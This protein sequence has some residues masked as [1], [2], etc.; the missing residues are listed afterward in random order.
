[1]HV[2]TAEGRRG[3]SEIESNDNDKGIPNEIATEGILCH[4][5]RCH[6][7]SD[8]NHHTDTD[9]GGGTEPDQSEDTHQFDLHEPGHC[10]TRALRHGETSTAVEG[11]NC[12]GDNHLAVPRANA[13]EHD[14]GEAPAHVDTA[15]GAAQEVGAQDEVQEAKGEENANFNSGNIF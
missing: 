15:E 13:D 7:R 6:S 4:G 1:M 2:I 11:G 3:S 10:W 12:P 14:N 5:T 9:R 8:S